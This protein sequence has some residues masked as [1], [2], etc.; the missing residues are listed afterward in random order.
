TDGLDAAGGVLQ[1]DRR[2]VVGGR[3]RSAAAAFGFGR[4]RLGGD[5]GG[6]AG[7]G[8]APAL[9]A[10]AAQ[11]APGRTERRDRCAGREVMERLLLDRVDAE[12]RG[13][14]GGGRN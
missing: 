6:L 12:A 1:E 11:A 4:G 7:F 3:G 13:A 10:P 9:A 8:E 5:G 14:T 2:I